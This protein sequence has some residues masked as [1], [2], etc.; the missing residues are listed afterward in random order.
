[1]D[2]NKNLVFGASSN[3]QGYLSTAS[4]MGLV[5]G[6]VLILVLYCSVIFIFS[7]QSL[8]RFDDP[9]GTTITVQNLH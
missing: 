8:D 7:I 6:V 4:L 3:C 5:A 1:M 2:K 9:R